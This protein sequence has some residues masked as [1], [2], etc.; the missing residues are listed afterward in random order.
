MID[1]EVLYTLKDYLFI[2]N[3]LFSC[4]LS[5]WSMKAGP[6]HSGGD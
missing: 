6:M 2:T 5:I 3:V 1:A 4:F